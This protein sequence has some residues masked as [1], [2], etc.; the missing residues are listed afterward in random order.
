MFKTGNIHI[1]NPFS[2][3]GRGFTLTPQIFNCLPCVNWCL[4]VLN[5]SWFFAKLSK[6][7]AQL[8]WTLAIFQTHPSSH[9]PDRESLFVHNFCIQLLFTIF[10]NCFCFQLFFETLVQNSFKTFVHNKVCSYFF[11]KVFLKNLVH[12]PY[13]NFLFTTFVQNFCPQL[14]FTRIV[15]K[16]CSQTIFTTFVTTHAHKFA[17]NFVRN[18]C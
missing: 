7:Q 4:K 2:H 18:F 9:P 8:C 11:S 6:P 5:L 1:F 14:L 15:H 13:S 3:G 12:N 17:H 10:D 16:Y